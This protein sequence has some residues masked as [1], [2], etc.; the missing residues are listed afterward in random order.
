MVYSQ[1]VSRVWVRAGW[2]PSLEIG[3]GKVG[4]K[5]IEKGLG[6]HG[7]EFMLGDSTH[8]KLGNE[9]IRFVF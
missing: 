1:P 3:T 9:I 5:Q 8:L 7:A 2:G 6:G 4:G